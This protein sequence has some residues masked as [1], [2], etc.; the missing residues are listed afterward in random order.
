M[1][2]KR[3]TSTKYQYSLTKHDHC[4]VQSFGDTH[5]RAHV[6]GAVLLRVFAEALANGVY[7]A[8]QPRWPVKVAR[9]IY[10]VDLTCGDA[11]FVSEIV[12]W[13]ENH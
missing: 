10:R 12:G 4:K 5:Q 13:H 3:L 7:V 8:L 2:G 11:L 9:V 6:T 1:S